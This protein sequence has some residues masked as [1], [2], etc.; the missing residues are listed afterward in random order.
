MLQKQITSYDPEN[1]RKSYRFNNLS[2]ETISTKK[3]GLGLKF[4]P[5]PKDIT[6][7]EARNGIVRFNNLL[8]FHFAHKYEKNPDHQD[9]LYKF[10]AKFKLS[11]KNL[12]RNNHVFKDNIIANALFCFEMEMGEI[13]DKSPAEE[14]KLNFRKFLYTFKKAN[15]DL[16]IVP[17]D[18][19]LGLTVLKL[20]DYDYLARKHLDQ[21]IYTLVKPDE[22]DFL[23]N[24]TL[25]LK[26]FISNEI[27][28]WNEEL[29]LSI[30][31]SKF[32]L[33]LEKD[34]MKTPKFHIMPKLHKGLKTV[35]NLGVRPI[36]GA[37]AAPTAH[38]SIWL[39][40]KLEEN[41]ELPF[42]I[43]NSTQIRLL[44][45]RNCRYNH[46]L[47]TID[48]V[49]LYNN[50]EKNEMLKTFREKWDCRNSR[51]KNVLIN[52][53]EFICDHNYLCYGGNTYKMTDSI[54][55][56]NNASV[57]LANLYLALTVDDEI[58]SY[59]GVECFARYI[60]DIFGIFNGNLAEFLDFKNKLD[61][62]TPTRLATTYN[63][64]RFEIPF[65]DLLVF[66]GEKHYEFKTYQKDLNTYQYIMPTSSHPKHV[67]SGFVKSEIRR[68]AQTNTRRQDYIWMIEKFR[69]RLLQRGYEED[70][71]N[72]IFLQYV[73]KLRKIALEE[74]KDEII[75]DHE[76][77]L[78]PLVLQ[79]SHRPIYHQVR[80][81]LKR[82][83][84][85]LQKCHPGAK[86]L[87][88]LKKADNIG[89]ILVRSSLTSDQLTFLGATE[90]K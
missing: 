62:L 36:V 65:L 60:D 71:I 8:K 27:I 74:K 38:L 80:G 31:E 63:W 26:I 42:V 52:V 29:E 44:L 37:V 13:L 85:E 41:I 82:L 66:K 11:K 20:V 12:I 67:F 48:Y 84:R 81:A 21:D 59:P 87:L 6:N 50:L 55:M 45:T 58:I 33:H 53:I 7:T 90:E 54:P 47:F 22:D 43:K 10:D 72:E 24:P 86:T 77:I 39:A 25:Y 69:I 78:L 79:F 64:Q 4:C 19:N 18:K 83:E 75:E 34:E 57:Q 61:R 1:I 2:G 14:R 73:W 15:P 5:K 30:Q 35:R 76:E 51:L 9:Y 46:H 56:G 70:W 89:D 32:L 28:P 88:A 23:K 40:K 17:A 3:L 16:I 49:G 68:Y